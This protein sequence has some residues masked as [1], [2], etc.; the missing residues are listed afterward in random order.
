MRSRAGVSLVEAT[1]ALLLMATGLLA[2][3]STGAR[4][5]QL[6]RRA[7]ALQG[8]TLA[9]A[10]VLDS[11]TQ[12]QHPTNGSARRERYALSWQVAASAGTSRI[13]LIIR[14]ADGSGTRADTFAGVAAPWPAR[15][16]HV[17]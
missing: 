12:L 16:Q 6:L 14:Y 11:L 10:S 2:V 8:A 7:A 9:A 15:L 17:P 4:S 1:L 13:E 3:A 5:A